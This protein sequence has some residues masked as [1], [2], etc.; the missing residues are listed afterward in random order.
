MGKASNANEARGFIEDIYSGLVYQGL[1]RPGD[2]D[3]Y[4]GI[5]L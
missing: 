2:K 3:R 1:E 5:L 4:L